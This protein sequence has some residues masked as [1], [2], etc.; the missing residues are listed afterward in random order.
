[1]KIYTHEGNGHYIG[2]A[3]V[4]I[5]GS[6]QT[7]ELLIRDFLDSSGL[8]EEKLDIKTEDLPKA[9]KVIYAVDGDY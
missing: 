9:G 4:V 7:A 6:K 8:S 2:S 5:A 3:V 1:M